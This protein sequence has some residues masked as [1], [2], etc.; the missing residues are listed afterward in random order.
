MWASVVAATLSTCAQSFRLGLQSED[1]VVVAQGLCRRRAESSWTRDKTHVPRVGR[2]I[3][4]HCTT[5]EV[6]KWILETC[7]FEFLFAVGNLTLLQS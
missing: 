5:K 7:L 4:I 1:S 3:L 2:W 6:L